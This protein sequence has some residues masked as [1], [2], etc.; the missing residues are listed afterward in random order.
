MPRRLILLMESN[1]TWLNRCRPTGTET[2]FTFPVN[3]IMTPLERHKSNILLVD[4]MKVYSGF[5]D[6]HFRGY[7]GLWTGVSAVG[8]SKESPGPGG[9]SIDRMWRQ[10]SVRAVATPV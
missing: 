8:T 9:K 2:A 10:R 7:T 5:G 6:Q 1:G 4:A 3:S